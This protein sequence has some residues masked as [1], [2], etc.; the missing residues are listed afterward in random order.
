[1][2]CKVEIAKER[3][4]GDRVTR[5]GIGKRVLK[6]KASEKECNDKDILKSRARY[7]RILWLNLRS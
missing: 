6:W 4:I 2:F 3:A 1:M 7:L 5:G